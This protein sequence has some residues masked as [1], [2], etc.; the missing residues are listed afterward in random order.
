[1]P[2]VLGEEMPPKLNLP[3]QCLL[4]DRAPSPLSFPIS[5]NAWI[6]FTD[7]KHWSLNIKHFA[8]VMSDDRCHWM[9]SGICQTLGSSKTPVLRES[10]VYRNILRTLSIKNIWR[11]THEVKP[12]ALA[13]LVIWIGFVL[14][15][16]NDF[17][18]LQSRS[19]IYLLP[20]YFYIYI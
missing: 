9:T 16:I 8:V 14:C 12:S 6:T 17:F 11:Q 19:Y 1:M 13:L 5:K 20:I 3:S 4:C 15:H 18:A 2:I 10:F 7:S